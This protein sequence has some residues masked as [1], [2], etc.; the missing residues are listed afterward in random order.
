MLAAA[1]EM[2]TTKADGDAPPERQPI[3]SSELFPA[4]LESLDEN[5]LAWKE[6]LCHELAIA[7]GDARRNIPPDQE[8]LGAA[9]AGANKRGLLPHEQ[10]VFKALEKFIDPRVFGAQH[11]HLGAVLAKVASQGTRVELGQG[12]HPTGRQARPQVLLRAPV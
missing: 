9:L 2:T 8:K 5:G 11:P 3:T 7:T 6:L 1:P 4:R 12:R 10:P